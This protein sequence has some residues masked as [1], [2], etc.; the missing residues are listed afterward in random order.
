MNIVE[1]G[2]RLYNGLPSELMNDLYDELINRYEEIINIERWDILSLYL[3]RSCA[4]LNK[5]YKK[6]KNKTFHI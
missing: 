2:N 5:N 6:N 4:I 1:R 3:A